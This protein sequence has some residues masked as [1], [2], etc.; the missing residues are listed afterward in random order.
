MKALRLYRGK[1]IQ[2]WFF[3]QG[4]FSME[5]RWSQDAVKEI[6]DQASILNMTGIE[7][8]SMMRDVERWSGNRTIVTRGQNIGGGAVETAGTNRGESRR[9]VLQAEDIRGIG[10]GRQIIKI[11]LAALACRP[12]SNSC[13]ATGRKSWSSSSTISAALRVA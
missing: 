10:A 13:A 5:G 8:P 6:E 1:G 11:A 7:D 3:A 9:P 4:R 12:C 2:L